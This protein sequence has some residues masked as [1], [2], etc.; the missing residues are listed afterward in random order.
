MSWLRNVRRWA[1]DKNR[2]RRIK[3][4]VG[5]ALKLYPS[6]S[7]LNTAKVIIDIPQQR[8]PGVRGRRAGSGEAR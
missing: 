7:T 5:L 2:Q 6:G 4:L 1:A 8:L 3:K